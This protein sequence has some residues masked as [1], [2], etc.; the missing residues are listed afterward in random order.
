MNPTRRKILRS[1]LAL[2]AVI[3]IPQSVAQ[4]TTDEFPTAPVRIIV[5]Y[6]PGGGLDTMARLIA[7]DLSKTLGQPVIVENRPGASGV[8][9]AEFVAKAKPDGHTLMMVASGHASVAASRPSQAIDLIQDF[10][11][12][13]MVTS[14]PLF[15]VVRKDS[16]I[17]SFED[18]VAR[19]KQ[20]PGE[21]SYPTPGVGT[22]QHLVAELIWNDMGIDLNH[23]PYKGAGAMMTDLLGGHVDVM[24]ETA[25]TTLPHFA[26]GTL[27]ALA[28]T[29]KAGE[30][31]VPEVRELIHL[32]GR[33]QYES[34][35]G[36][37]APNDVPGYITTRLNDAIGQSKQQP[38]IR[39]KIIELGGDVASLTP[40][41][42]KNKA[43]F[44][45]E[46]FKKLIQDRGIVLR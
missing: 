30:K 17:R 14:Y 46:R 45:Y 34:W 19:A 18:L 38:E 7:T 39:R 31:L 8:V 6:V 2:S 24:V 12:L 27:R 23:I 32:G 42:F 40:E 41:E 33:T 35:I 5:G 16:P 36:I 9:A 4:T 20:A 44:D 37:V 15:V 22:G 29:A 13:N 43:E 28:T 21:L 26:A 25:T 11:W 10:T 1:C 3:T